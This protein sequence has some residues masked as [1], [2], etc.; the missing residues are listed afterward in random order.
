[1]TI[2]SQ[3]FVNISFFTEVGGGGGGCLF[4]LALPKL[5]GLA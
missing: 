4:L 1:M 5:T 3:K 2:V